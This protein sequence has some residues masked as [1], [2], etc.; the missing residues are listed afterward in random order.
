MTR[1]IY[2][3]VGA[4]VPYVTFETTPH[5]WKQAS[6]YTYI[7]DYSTHHNEIDFSLGKSIDQSV[8]TGIDWRLLEVSGTNIF[9]PDPVTNIQRPEQD[10]PSP[11]PVLQPI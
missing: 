7:N 1:D 11:G 8:S 3:D 6:I 4:H 10:L 9:S 5:N 2:A